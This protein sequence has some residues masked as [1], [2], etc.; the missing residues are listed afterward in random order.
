MVSVGAS[1]LFFNKSPRYSSRGRSFSGY[2]PQGYTRSQPFTS[3]RNINYQSSAPVRSQQYVQQPQQFRGFSNAPGVRNIFANDNR[4]VDVESKV[5]EVLNVPV[6]EDVRIN[7]PNDQSSPSAAAALA[8]MKEVSGKDGL[9]GVPAEAFLQAVLSG[10]SREVA[11]AEAGRAY[12]EAYNRGERLA[13]GGAC[14]K[15]DRAFRQA[16]V[17]GEDP[18]LESTLAYINNWPGVTEGNPCA[19]SGLQYVKAIVSGKSHLEAT[20]LSVASFAKSFKALAQAG[21]PLK[22]NACLESTRAFWNAIPQRDKTDQ[23]HA[24]AFFA[25]ADKIFN[26]NAPAYDPVCLASL[27]GFF[28]SYLAGDDLLTANLKSARSFFAEFQKG[29]SRVPAD[30]ACAA[31]TVA[32]AEEI[33]NK[34][35]APNA[36][37]MIAYIAEAVKSGERRLDP[38]CGEATL[39]YWDAYIEQK[40]E[41]AANEAAA[42]AYLEALDKNP[43]FD[44]TSACARSAEAYI[45]EFN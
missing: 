41:A 29:N 4:I 1:P 15:A 18:V 8:Y 10:K 23:A 33:L 3:F 43:N 20:T 28:E 9:C 31:A 14:E 13:A 21:K 16:V 40:S 24:K 19:L 2:K 30:S 6:T 25:F 45:A 36:A 17:D 44:Q 11:T 34:P 32:Y 7:A 27:E 26:G 38:V 39:A 22:D 12:L 42:V 37:G 5:Q 35:S